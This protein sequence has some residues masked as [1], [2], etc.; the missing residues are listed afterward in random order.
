M[1]GRGA[2]P[3]SGEQGNDPAHQTA[4]N[5]PCNRGRT[6]ARARGRGGA[7]SPLV[8]APLA[9]D[10]R[11]KEV[12]TMIKRMTQKALVLAVSLAPALVVLAEV[13]GY[14]VP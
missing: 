12:P 2:H 14:K 5:D 6:V 4:R 7:E 8:R 11:R 3:S 13:A 9:I 1:T 10:L